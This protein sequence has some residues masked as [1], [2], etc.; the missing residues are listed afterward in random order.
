MAVSL[1]KKG[2]I[3]PRPKHDDSMIK[4]FKETRAITYIMK[5]I[6]DRITE[7]GAPVGKSMSDRVLIVRARTGSGKSTTIPVEVYRLFNP[8]FKSVQDDSYRSDI[9]GTY[10]G[11]NILCTQPRVLTAIDIAENT[12]KHYPFMKLDENLGYL[13]GNF[14]RRIL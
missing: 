10:T 6:K 3:I 1:I 5:W 11:A 9:K 12:P 2:S 14:K 7:Y 13:T 4:M 8:S